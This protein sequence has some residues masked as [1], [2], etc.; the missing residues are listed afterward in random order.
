M[1][2][3]RSAVYQIRL[4]PEEKHR[5]EEGAWRSRR[6]LAALIR[7]GVEAQLATLEQKPEPSTASSPADG[8]A[9]LEATLAKLGELERPPTARVA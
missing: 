5:W 7:D 9:G 2:R 6:T 8:L 3:H 1:A 4:A